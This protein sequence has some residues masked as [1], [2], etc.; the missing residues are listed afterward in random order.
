MLIESPEGD[1]EVKEIKGKRITKIRGQ[2]EMKNFS[3]EIPADPSSA[4]FFVV[5]TLL[6]KNSKLLIKI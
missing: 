1:I 3:V 2:V 6:T 4:C 5:Q